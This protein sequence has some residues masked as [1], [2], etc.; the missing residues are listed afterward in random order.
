MSW[1]DNAK[2]V[3][4]RILG[5]ID[6]VVDAGIDVGGKALSAG[7]EATRRAS[8]EEDKKNPEPVEIAKHT[9]GFGGHTRKTPDKKIPVDGIMSTPQKY[10]LKGFGH[11]DRGTAPL[12]IKRSPDARRNRCGSG[13]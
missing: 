8:T 6:D 4:A 10:F 12:R 11:R 7:M 9:P 3:F 1:V 5:K 2:K 13:H